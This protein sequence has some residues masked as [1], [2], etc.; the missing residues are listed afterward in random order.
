MRSRLRKS[1]GR[2]SKCRRRAVTASS[3]TAQ[4]SALKDLSAT[5]KLDGV[6]ILPFTFGRTDRTG[7]ADQGKRAPS[8]PWSTVASPTR[9]SRTS[10][11]P[12]TTSP[13]VPIRRLAFR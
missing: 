2:L 7:R 8:F 13:W 5:R 4:V 12:A 10:M 9:R 11:S 1:R 6:V 3:A